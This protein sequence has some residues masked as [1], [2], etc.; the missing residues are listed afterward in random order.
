MRSFSRKDSYF[1]DILFISTSFPTIATVHG[2]TL[3]NPHH[4]NRL[5]KGRLLLI[6]AGLESPE[7]YASD[8]T[9]TFPVSGRFTS[10][11][12]EIYEI[13]LEAQNTVI[14]SITPIYNMQ[15]ILGEATPERPADF[16]VVKK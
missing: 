16:D 12:K 3:H 8:I 14:Q 10:M 1:L 5:Q 15:W 6:D 7:F 4:G 9:R 11:Q 2:E 13:V